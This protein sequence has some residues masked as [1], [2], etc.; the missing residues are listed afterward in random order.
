MVGDRMPFRTSPAFT[1]TSTGLRDAVGVT[2]TPKPGYP[3][4]PLPTHLHQALLTIPILSRVRT[5]RL[6]FSYRQ[7][8]SSSAIKMTPT[9]DVIILGAGPVGENVADRCSQGGLRVAIIE[10]EL[11][12][13]ECS[14]WACMPSKALIRPGLA[15]RAAQGISGARQAATGGIDV[16]QVLKRRNYITGDWSDQGGEGWLQSAGIELIRG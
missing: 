14:F 13:G 16:T 15:V 10:S 11:V 3:S 2:I 8:T 4:N 1:R 7:F 9:H 12:G 5:L 6:P